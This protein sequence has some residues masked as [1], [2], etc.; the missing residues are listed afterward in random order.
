M[1]DERAAHGAFILQR[2]VSRHRL[3]VSGLRPDMADVPF[4]TGAR[5]FPARQGF[6]LKS[7]KSSF[8]W[9]FAGGFVLGAIGLF[10]LHPSDTPSAF[11]APAPAHVAE[12]R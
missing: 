5:W 1:Q 6:M 9:Q 4:A 3:V 2:Y 7:F 12:T 8:V 10:A 11:P